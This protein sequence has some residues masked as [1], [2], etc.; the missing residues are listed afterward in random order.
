MLGGRGPPLLLIPGGHYSEQRP[1]TGHCSEHS[2]DRWTGSAGPVGRPG[3][4]R[5]GLDRSGRARTIKKRC[6]CSK[7]V[8]WFGLV[9]DGRLNTP[10][11]RLNTP[12]RTPRWTPKTKKG[13]LDRKRFFCMFFSSGRVRRRPPART[14]S[15][16][17]N[18]VRSN[19]L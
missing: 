16:Y 3:R 7:N 6:F 1:F 10:F 12:F 11:G 19:V 8:F 4:V 5:T 18:Y 13:V 14:L 2:P 17:P 15:T 9:R